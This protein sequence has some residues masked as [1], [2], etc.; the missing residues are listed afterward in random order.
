MYLVNNNSV[1]THVNLPSLLGQYS[2]K[3]VLIKYW[4]DLY[5]KNKWPFSNTF[6]I[7]F[8]HFCKGS[9]QKYICFFW[10]KMSTDI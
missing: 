10:K 8:S 4:I 2:E 6:Y 3:I 7:L 5:S 1:F 9:R